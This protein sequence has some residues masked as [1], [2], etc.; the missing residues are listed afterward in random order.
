MFISK[1]VFFLKWHPPSIS[2]SSPS[3]SSKTAW[4]EVQ[5][6]EA[7][8]RDDLLHRCQR[9][10]WKWCCWPKR[11]RITNWAF[12]LL[13]RLEKGDIA[14][15]KY[16]TS[17]TNIAPVAIFSLPWQH[18]WDEHPTNPSNIGIDYHRFT[19]FPTQKNVGESNRL[20]LPSTKS[21]QNLHQKPEKNT[22]FFMNGTKIPT[23]AYEKV[24]HL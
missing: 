24:L 11:I 7:E 8:K 15:R 16:V 21:I 14:P 4:T 2:L 19:S 13:W 3:S 5:N 12:D 18:C 9:L 10:G 1:R 6:N 22:A 23:K 17:S 20:H